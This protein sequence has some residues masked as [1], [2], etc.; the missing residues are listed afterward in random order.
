MPPRMIFSVMG[1]LT[2]A[3]VILGNA[4]YA[5]RTERRL[6]SLQ[7]PSSPSS[8][9]SQPPFATDLSLSLQDASAEYPAVARL[10]D[11][12]AVA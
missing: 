7:A 11:T 6:T 12:R 3:D 9:P 4:V 1:T 10:N 5:D 2:D 8:P